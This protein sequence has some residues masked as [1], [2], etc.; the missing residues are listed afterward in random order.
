MNFNRMFLTLTLWFKSHWQMAYLKQ[1]NQSKQAIFLLLLL[2]IALFISCMLVISRLNLTF[3]E[4]VIS[5]LREEQL[6]DSFYANLDR[7]NSQQHLLERYTDDL[8]LFAQAFHSLHRVGNTRVQAELGPAIKGKLVGFPKA[9]GVGVWFDSTPGSNAVSLTSYVYRDSAQ[10][11]KLTLLTGRDGINYRYQPWFEQYQTRTNQQDPNATYLTSAYFNS[12]SNAAVMTLVKPIL[13]KDGAQIGIVSTD[14]HAEQIINLV[15]QVQV[16]PNTFAYLIDRNNSIL[17]GLSNIEDMEQVD[18]I[19]L[20]IQQSRLID[21]LNFN[22]LSGG[23]SVQRP[24]VIKEQLTVEGRQ[25]DLS[26]AA[27]NAGMLFGIGVPRDEIDAVL[28]PIRTRNMQ[29]LWFST[30]FMV[31]LSALLLRWTLGVMRQLQASYKDELTNLPNRARLLLDLSKGDRVSLVLV[32]LD[33]F[34]EVNG[35]FGYACG[36]Y[37]LQS[38]AGRLNNGIDRQSFGEASLYRLAADEFA[39]VTHPLSSEHLILFLQHIQQM[40]DTQHLS[41]QLQEIPVRMTLGAVVQDVNGQDHP[42]S[43]ITRAEFAL[44][45]ARQQQKGFGIY[46]PDQHIEEIYQYNLLWAGYVKEA[47]RDDRIIPYFQPIYDNAN[48]RVSKYE[49]LVRMQLDNGQIANPGQ[50]LDVA[51]KVRLDRQLTMVMVEKSFKKFAGTDLEFS[52]NLSYADLL[53]ENL[54]AF[55]S[56]K[57]D[58]TAIGPQVIFEIL[59]SESIENYHGVKRFIDEVKSRGCRIAIDDFGTGYSNFEHL[60]RMKVDIIKI[61][62]SLIRNLDQDFVALKVTQ[63]IVHF[64]NSLNM[65][66]VA[67]F[68]HNEAIQQHV[69][70][71]G[72]NFSQ[73]SYISMPQVDLML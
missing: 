28:R 57:L 23:L 3:S 63:G 15:S 17:S 44:Q 33:D 19:M 37:V 22:S 9:F 1:L 48:N 45:Q 43:L 25:Y 69:R 7:L 66:T 10:H 13:D 61:D 46:Q 24:T 60:L 8:A 16:T 36:D 59:E 4:K 32:N 39:I 64:A 47:L 71:L 49:C 52:I 26:Y 18:E 56:Q 58:E 2:L 34:K 70:R 42:N 14:W 50:F 5:E 51:R 53:D 35:L 12:L 72:I 30:L 65:T 54:T 67:E 40:L 20:H 27:S 55:I 41:W 73:G 31:G 21:K 68:V 62:G 38:I 11:S 29:I 6:E